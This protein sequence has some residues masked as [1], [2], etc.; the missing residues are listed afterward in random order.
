MG[1]NIL[2]KPRVIHSYMERFVS[3]QQ[4]RAEA[5]ANNYQEFV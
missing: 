4:R 2:G 5:V 1:A 3:Y